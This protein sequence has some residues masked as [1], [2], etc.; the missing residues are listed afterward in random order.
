MA[1]M[2]SCVPVGRWRGTTETEALPLRGDLSPPHLIS[3][4]EAPSWF[5]LPHLHWERGAS[6]QRHCEFPLSTCP[7]VLLGEGLGK[8]TFSGPFQSPALVLGGGVVRVLLCPPPPLFF[9]LGLAGRWGWRRAASFH[10]FWGAIFLFRVGLHCFGRGGWSCEGETC[11]S[12]RG[13]WEGGQVLPLKA[14]WVMEDTVGLEEKEKWLQ[15]DYPNFW[16]FLL[17]GGHR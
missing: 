5:P 6:P 9:P 15:L 10:Q 8:G 11:F 7:P 4:E 13:G 17:P 1:A 16:A 3:L 12:W 2:R 14:W